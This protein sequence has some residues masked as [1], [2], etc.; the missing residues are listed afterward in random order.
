MV[1]AVAAPIALPAVFARIF[2]V[3]L[4]KIAEVFECILVKK[5]SLIECKPLGAY[6]QVSWIG[7]SYP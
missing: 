7:G 5:L 1:E 3:G 4:A 6:R 2:D